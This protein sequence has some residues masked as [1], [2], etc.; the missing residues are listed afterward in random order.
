M[1]NFEWLPKQSRMNLAHIFFPP[2]IYGAGLKRAKFVDT[3][4]ELVARIL[5]VPARI[6]QREDQL[7]QTARHLRTRVAQCIEFDGGIFERL[8]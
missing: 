3:L 8:L 1:F 7:G 4:D 2:F 5:D 6:E